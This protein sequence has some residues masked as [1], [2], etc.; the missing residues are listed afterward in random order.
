MQL[1]LSRLLIIALTLLG[2]PPAQSQ[3][4]PLNVPL[5]LPSSTLIPHYRLPITYNSTTVLVFA[6]AVRPVDRGD[7]DVLAQKQP[8]ADNILKLKAARRNF[9]PTNLH[10]FTSDG[11][12][13]AFNIIYTDSL[14][15][16]YDISRLDPASIK[17]LGSPGGVGVG[18]LAAIRA[19]R[20]NF[21]ITTRRYRMRL[22]L[23]NI[24]RSGLLLFLR[25]ALSN[26]SNLDYTPDFLRLYLADEARAK[27]TSRQELEIT[28]AYTDTLPVVPGSATRSFI[29]VLPRMTIPDRKILRVELYE[30]NGGRSLS[31]KINNRELF[32]S[33]AI[34]LP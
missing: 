14:A 12:L 20:P 13:F 33:H 30:K 15:A 2:I 26:R 31:L 9:P 4:L 25:F 23:D 6:T 18:E 10:V 29:L 8:G 21:E 7:R 34:P 22:R 11:R 32:R 24:D 1:L 19:Q 16:T 17:T 3:P 27:R 5:T 28:P